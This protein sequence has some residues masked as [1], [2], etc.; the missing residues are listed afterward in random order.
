L[1]IK[2]GVWSFGK[3]HVKAEDVHREHGIHNLEATRVAAQSGARRASNL[4]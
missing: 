1:G 4:E 2:S 3:Q